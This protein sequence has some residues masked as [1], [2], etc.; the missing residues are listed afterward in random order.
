MGT[1]D[2]GG[3][4]TSFLPIIFR[5]ESSQ[6]V[7]TRG[8]VIGWL[9]SKD[10]PVLAGASGSSVAARSSTYYSPSSDGRPQWS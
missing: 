10:L 1:V 8:T 3:R 4:P 6:D 7:S 9:T 2:D 5:H